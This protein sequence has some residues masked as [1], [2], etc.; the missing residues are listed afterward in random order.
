MCI[1][2]AYVTQCPTPMAAFAYLYSIDV[3][4]FVSL[5]VCVNANTNKTTFYKLLF[6]I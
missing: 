2:E 3:K 1:T 4:N 5:C 6:K